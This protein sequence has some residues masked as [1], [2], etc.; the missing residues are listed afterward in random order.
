M[1]T[2][3]LHIQKVPGTPLGPF[4]GPSPRATLNSAR[5]IGNQSTLLDYLLAAGF[6]LHFMPANLSEALRHRAAKTPIWMLWA[7]WVAATV[8]EHLGPRGPHEA[9]HLLAV[10]VRPTSGS[11][12]SS[13]NTLIRAA[14]LVTGGSTRSKCCCRDGRAQEPRKEGESL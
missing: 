3:L 6:G 10:R 14:G 4:G 9:F 5:C 13:L 7:M 8:L 12:E 11:P 1:K 2:P